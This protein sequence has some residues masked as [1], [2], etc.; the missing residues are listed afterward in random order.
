MVA[1]VVCIASLVVL[2]GV[3]V[4]PRPAEAQVNLQGATRVEFS[5]N[6]YDLTNK[7]TGFMLAGLSKITEGGAEFA[8]TWL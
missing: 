4:S 8:A 3:V 5:G 2:A 7:P 6:V 1:K